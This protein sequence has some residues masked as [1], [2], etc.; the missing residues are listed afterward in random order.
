MSSKDS[1]RA[2]LGALIATPAPTAD[3]DPDFAAHQARRSAGTE[4]TTDR[5][6]AATDNRTHKEIARVVADGEKAAVVAVQEETGRR[7]GFSV[8]E[9]DP[10]A[11]DT[12]R[13]L[14]ARTARTTGA[15]A[16]RGGPAVL[17]RKRAERVAKDKLT[18]QIPVAVLD[19]LDALILRDSTRKYDEVEEALRAHLQLKGIQLDEE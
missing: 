16:A 3:E 7:G 11:I 19:G 1:R 15:L 18:V 6:W 10:N 2:G 17:P 12:G 9:V 14:P 4:T 13:R 8:Q 5:L